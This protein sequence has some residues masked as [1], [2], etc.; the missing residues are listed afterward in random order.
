MGVFKTVKRGHVYILDVPGT[1]CQKVFMTRD[2]NPNT[3]RRSIICDYG[4]QCVPKLHFGQHLKQRFL[5]LYVNGTGLS[6]PLNRPTSL[7]VHLL[8]ILKHLSRFSTANQ[9]K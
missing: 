6:P 9:R 3:L 7:D 4:S 5:I 1:H 2:P 8:N